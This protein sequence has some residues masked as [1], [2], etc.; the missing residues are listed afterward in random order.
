MNVKRN[1]RAFAPF[2]AL[3]ILLLVSL[4]C[5]G[6]IIPPSSATSPDG[7][8]EARLTQTSNSINSAYE[9]IEISTG[10]LVLSTYPKYSSLNDVKAAKFSD[11][12]KKFAVAYHYNQGES[13][14]WVGVWS[15]ETGDFLYQKRIEGFT[16]NLNGVFDNLS[17]DY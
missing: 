13:Y 10:K 6:N 2:V 4:A 17:P 12:S 8:F 11:D 7:R 1:T 5:G 3:A 14:T 16:K 9:V 15:T